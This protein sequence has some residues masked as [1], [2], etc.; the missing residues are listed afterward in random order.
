M[1]TGKVHFTEDQSTNLATLYGRAVDARAERPVLGDPTAA[2]A[3]ARIDYDFDKFKI[4][5]TEAFS[6]ASRGKVFDLLVR[7][8][9]A[10]HEESTV[11]HLGCGMDS[12]VFRI[13]PPPTVRWF[14]V[15]FPDVIELRRQVYPERPGTTMLDASVTDTA[16]LA[17]VPADRP[18]LVVAEGLTMY[19]E[20]AAGRA[21]LR[22]LAEHFPSGEMIFD[23]YSRLGIKLQKTNSVVRR[24]KATLRWGIDDPA[25]L[26]RLGLT[27]VSRKTAED[28]IVKSDLDRLSA[29]VRLQYRLLVMIPALRNMGQ[30]LRF[31]F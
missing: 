16:W 15:D 23:A 4:G 8:F 26:E 6:I 29:P 2:D 14:D 24:A 25:E 9:L 1:T 3:V 13:A 7:D 28:F 31:R 27:L 30:L 5:K 20:P 17:E 22:R 21:L 11:V 12:R 19:L 18:A 10:A